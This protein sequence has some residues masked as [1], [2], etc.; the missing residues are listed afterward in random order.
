MIWCP[1]CN[2]PRN[3]T[4]WN[5]DDPVLNCGHIKKSTPIN[6]TLNEAW[7]GF[8]LLKEYLKIQTNILVELGFT[9][10][11]AKILVAEA[12]AK[13]PLSVQEL[14]DFTRDHLS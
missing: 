12:F 9:E 11:R 1:E 6:D 8:Q 5:R 3:I 14:R 4:G 2:E 7:T 10:N 13:D